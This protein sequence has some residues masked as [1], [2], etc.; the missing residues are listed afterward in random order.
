MFAPIHAQFTQISLKEWYLIFEY[1]ESLLNNLSMTLTLV[2]TLGMGKWAIQAVTY[3]T[4]HIIH[5]IGFIL[6]ITSNILQ[7]KLYIYDEVT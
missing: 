6:P 1:M 3:F 2:V 7:Q 5:I 4:Y